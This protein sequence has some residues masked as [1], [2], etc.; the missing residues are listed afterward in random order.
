MIIMK[1]ILVVFLSFILII[2]FSGC[3]DKDNE[4]NYREKYYQENFEPLK[5]LDLFI[6]EYNKKH[7]NGYDLGVKWCEYHSVK[8]TEADYD[9]EYTITIGK[10]ELDFNENELDG[11]SRKF[12]IKTKKVINE[13]TITYTNI[14]SFC[15]GKYCEKIE[16]NGKYNSI[17]NPRTRNAIEIKFP[18]LNSIFNLH[19]LINNVD[20]GYDITVYNQ[21]ITFT[22]SEEIDN[23]GRKTSIYQY[24]FDK[25]YNFITARLL[26]TMTYFENTSLKNYSASYSLKFCDEEN[27]DKERFNGTKG[28]DIYEIIF[29]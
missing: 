2:S 25:N 7:P 21:N 22:K 10:I 1:K 3:I 5:D 23:L 6:S 17:Y 4:L 18:F 27:I 28:E 13:E 24:Y 14:K 29:E 16:E 19:S 11:K 12:N 9:S 20:N 8:V 15:D 26:V